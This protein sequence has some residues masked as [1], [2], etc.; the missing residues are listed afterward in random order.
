MK[1]FIFFVIVLSCVLIFS[2]CA[3]RGVIEGGGKDSIPPVIIRSSPK[4]NTVFF[5]EEKILLNFN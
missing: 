4:E 3:T 1:N 5:K 2:K